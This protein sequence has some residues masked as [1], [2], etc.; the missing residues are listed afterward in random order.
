MS[1]PMTSMHGA[2]NLAR[3]LNEFKDE[4][5]W[6]QYIFFG[7]DLKTNFLGSETNYC[8]LTHQ[9]GETSDIAE[10]LF[11]DLIIDLAKVKDHHY[12]CFLVMFW[13]YV[14]M[15]VTRSVLM[16]YLSRYF[17]LCMNCIYVEPFASY[18]TEKMAERSYRWT[19]A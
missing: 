5:G 17:H 2:A 3:L 1:T 4:Q 14:S 7:R 19:H 6:L 12:S 15:Q 11:V 16:S 13:Y 18:L 9:V 8:M 10:E